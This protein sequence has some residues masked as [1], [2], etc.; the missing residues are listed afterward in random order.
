VVTRTKIPASAKHQPHRRLQWV[1]ER[2]N[3][4]RR[5]SDPE[6]KCPNE[7]TEN[8]MLYLDY[9]P[10]SKANG[11][12]ELSKIVWAKKLNQ[13][14]LPGIDLKERVT[15]VGGRSVRVR[16]LSISDPNSY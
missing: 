13:L 8:Q 6:I 1:L 5:L 2:T 4:G 12:K 16:G 15:R 10:W 7:P 9:V 14:K 3:E 11:Y